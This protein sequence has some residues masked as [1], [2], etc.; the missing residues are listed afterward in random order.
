MIAMTT[1]KVLVSYSV[2]LPPLGNDVKF[3][4]GNSGFVSRMTQVTDIRRIQ[5]KR[6]SS[7]FLDIAPLNLTSILD[8]EG[9]LDISSTTRYGPNLEDVETELQ[10]KA[11]ELRKC[12]LKSKDTG[13]VNIYRSC[14]R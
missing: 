3:K 4:R 9:L 12:A 14:R 8:L 2:L 13:G 5:K 1:I 10:L 6:D 11:L 7:R